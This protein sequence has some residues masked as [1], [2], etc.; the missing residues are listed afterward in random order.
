[1]GLVTPFFSGSYS[2]ADCI[3]LLN[4]VD[5][6]ELSVS[7]KDLRIRQK[8]SHYS[9]TLTKETAPSA[10]TMVLHSEAIARN[11]AKLAQACVSLAA[12][13]HT[14]LGNKIA[15]VSLAR[16]G[17]PIGVVVSR[18]LRER[19]VACP[20][21]SISVVRD[22]GAD[23]AALKYIWDALGPEYAVAFVDGWTGKGVISGE[24]ANSVHIFNKQTGANFPDKIWVVSDLGGS[25]GW[26]ADYN[27]W[28]IPSCMLNSTIS[29]LVSRTLVLSD[30]K[31]GTFHSCKYL[32]HLAG[33]DVSNEFVDTIFNLTK[34]L[35]PVPLAL[36]QGKHCN[37]QL[38]QET[39]RR[40][41]QI[42]DVSDKNWVKLGI[43]E[44]TRV[45][46]RR[47]PELLWL[48]NIVDADT[49][50]LV[51]LAT[52]RGVPIQV[53]ASLEFKAAALIKSKD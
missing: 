34:G 26:S 13:M 40:L 21:F 37:K 17:T 4:P 8:V 39:L 12:A 35:T 42:A 44:A 31:P 38:M 46:L 51:E 47:V 9:E 22:K 50:H 32:G 6:E 29:G 33:I 43:G 45:L 7:E 1:M 5:F 49:V 14:Q 30:H 24:I 3:F 20:H 36:A 25:A 18:I 15:V 53:D 27:D 2:S 48:R 41:M 19:G 52:L 11:G 28:L 23:L 10:E 16:A